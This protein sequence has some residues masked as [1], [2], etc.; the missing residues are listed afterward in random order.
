M[1]SYQLSSARRFLEVLK[2]LQNFNPSKYNNR[3]CTVMSHLMV[4]LKSN[5]E[6]T[7]TVITR[8][9]SCATEIL[10]PDNRELH[11]RIQKFPWLYSSGTNGRINDSKNTFSLQYGIVIAIYLL[12]GSSSSESAARIRYL[13]KHFSVKDGGR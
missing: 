11:L 7:Y 3:A 12:V 13:G 8:F 6:R 4:L 1:D 10:L 5:Y 2:P 9:V